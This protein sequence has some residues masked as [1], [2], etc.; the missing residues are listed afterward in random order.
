MEEPV[1]TQNRYVDATGANRYDARADMSS[2]RYQSWLKHC[3]P[4]N[5]F[6]HM[7]S[8][9]NQLFGNPACSVRF[10]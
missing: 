3:V 9:S 6:L 8:L 10:F 1:K 5:R 7:V 4:N 2:V